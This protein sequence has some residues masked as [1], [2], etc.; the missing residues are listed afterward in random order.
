MIFACQPSTLNLGALLEVF[1]RAMKQEEM[2]NEISVAR[3]RDKLAILAWRAT[4][5][6]CRQSPFI[7]QALALRERLQ[8]SQFL[9]PLKKL[10]LLKLHPDEQ[11]ANPSLFLSLKP[12]QHC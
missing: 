6:H 9:M 12:S 3:S 4:L 8:T 1:K 11:T 10:K 2:K 5:T 7:L